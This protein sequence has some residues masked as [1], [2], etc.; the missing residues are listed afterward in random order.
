MMSSTAIPIVETP[1][2]QSPNADDATTALFGSAFHKYFS[3]IIGEKQVQISDP[4]ASPLPA[5]FAVTQHFVHFSSNIL[6]YHPL[7]H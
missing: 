1:P 5:I 3:D 7:S 6:S 4:E 2:P